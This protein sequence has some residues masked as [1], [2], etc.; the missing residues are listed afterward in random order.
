MTLDYSVP[1]K[2]KVDMTDYVKEMLDEFSD[3]LTGK[4]ASSAN[5]QLFDSTRGSKLSDLKAEAFHQMV[6]KALFLTMRA[7]PDIRLAVA[8]LYTRVKEPTTYDWFKLVCMMNFLKKTRYDSL[9]IS[10][11]AH[12]R[13]CGV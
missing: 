2:V 9:T 7:R 8:Y 13:S 10:L 6:A 1:G 5:E 11:T 4:V 3:E 12:T